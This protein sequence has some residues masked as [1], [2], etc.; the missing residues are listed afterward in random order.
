MLDKGTQKHDKYV[1]VKQ[2]NALL[3]V[4]SPAAL[5]H[6]SSAHWTQKPLP[7]SG[8][9]FTKETGADSESLVVMLREKKQTCVSA[10]LQVSF[11]LTFQ[12]GG[13]LL[14]LL[15]PSVRKDFL[16]HFVNIARDLIHHILHFPLNIGPIFQR[17]R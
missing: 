4:E 1:Q 14:Q 2:R 11:H 5:L 16:V 15:C 13:V 17:Q 3:C 8:T 6:E 9:L 7:S 12:V 10:Y